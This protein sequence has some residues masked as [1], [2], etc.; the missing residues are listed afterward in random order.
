M[1]VPRTVTDLARGLGDWFATAGSG[2]SRSELSHTDAVIARH[3]TAE[4]AAPRWQAV[5]ERVAP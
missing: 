2:Q 5:L 4:V 1:V 3:Y